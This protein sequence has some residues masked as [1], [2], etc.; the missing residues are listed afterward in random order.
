MVTMIVGIGAL[1]AVCLLAVLV[2]ARLFRK[3]EQ[4]RRP[5]PRRCRLDRWLGLTEADAG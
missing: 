1:V 4:G 3:V 2:V 5:C